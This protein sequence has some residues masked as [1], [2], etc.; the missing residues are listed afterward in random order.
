M[1]NKLSLKSKFLM[2]LLFVLAVIMPIDEFNAERWYVDYIP[3][4]SIVRLIFVEIKSE[5]LIFISVIGLAFGVHQLYKINVLIYLILY[6]LYLSAVLLYSGSSKEAIEY[7]MSCFYIAGL[8]CFLSLTFE[9]ACSQEKIIKTLELSVVFSI[10]LVIVE[11]LLMG[12]DGLYWNG[13]MYALTP[14]PNHA[15]VYFTLAF[16]FVLYSIKI[17]GWNSVRAM[18]LI[19]LPFL[20]Y[21]TGSRTSLFILI[22]VSL[23]YM[24]YDLLRM[25]TKL[26]VLSVLFLISSSFIFFNIS[27]YFSIF[28]QDTRSDGL[29]AALQRFGDNPLFGSIA[30]EKM[31]AV[32]HVENS[33]VSALDLTGLIGFGLIIFH[34]TYLW[35]HAYKQRAVFIILF[36]PY[37][38]IMIFEAI[39]FSRTNFPILFLILIVCICSHL[40]SMKTR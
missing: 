5:F 32:L 37:L 39:A 21:E 11:Y 24:F 14:N 2:G 40:K 20:S 10:F 7:F 4:M 16:S 15:G 27:D 18:L 17:Y 6:F 8:F 22:F 34:V 38:S 30:V 29:S 19:A 31:P 23:V 12:E 3:N 25:Q 26:W 1:K 33:F 13:R 36:V 9:S 28:G 35:R